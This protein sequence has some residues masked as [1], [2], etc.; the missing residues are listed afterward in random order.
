MTEKLNR[1]RF[2]DSDKLRDSVDLLAPL[3]GVLSLSEEQADAWSFIK[4]YSDRARRISSAHR[5]R[6]LEIDWL[7]RYE[8]GNR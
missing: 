2:K 7:K 5:A 1:L 8:V 6:S 3:V 4:F